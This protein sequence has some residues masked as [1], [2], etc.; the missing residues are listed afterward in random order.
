MKWEELN[1][2]VEA[3]GGGEGNGDSAGDAVGGSNRQDSRRCRNEY[4]SVQ[5]A[6]DEG[7]RA[8]SLLWGGVGIEYPYPFG[9]AGCPIAEGMLSQ[10]GKIMEGGSEA[11]GMVTSAGRDSL[12]FWS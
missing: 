9:M 4:H 2:R 6:G 10:P 5:N 11:V 8:W 7:L 12:G 3:D 1:D